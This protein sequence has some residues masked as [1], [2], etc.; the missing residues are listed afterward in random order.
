MGNPTVS[1]IIPTY[2]GARF[3]GEAMQS[4]FEQTYPDFELIV[5]N[6]ASPDNTCEAVKQFDD[7]RLIYLVHEENQGADVAR[8]TGLQASSGEIIAFLDQDDL[9]HPE[10]LQE[11]VIFLERDPDVGMTYNA[12]F[13]LNYSSKTIRELWRPPCSIT[14]ADLVLWFPISPS[15]S[16][17]RR[18][19]AFEMDLHSDNS[20]GSEISIL[21]HLFMSGCGFGLVDRALN[22]RRYH[23]RRKVKDLAR[24]CESELSNQIKVFSDARCPAEVLALRGV[25]HSNLYRYWSYLAFGQGETALGQKFVRE[26]VRLKPSLLEGRPCELVQFLLINCIDDESEN[27][28]ALLQGIFAQ[29][30]PEIAWLSEQS[31]WAVAQGYLLKGAR[32]VIWDRPEDGR[33]HFEHAANLC[34]QVDEPFLST[35][36]QKLLNYEA[37][38]G[39]EATQNVLCSLTPYLESLGDRAFVRDLKSSYSVNRAF[40]SYDAGD[41]ATVPM[42]ILHAIANN[43][44]YLANRGVVSILLRSTFGMWSKTV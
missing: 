10:K 3:L 37:E 30:P 34:A 17:L 12:R 6:D 4:V 39:V 13:E 24:A 2:N 33:R 11:H 8:H 19:W 40:R 38:F 35:L 5:V 18:K 28:E 14:L 15:D 44:K 20:R 29:M 21:S 7:P 25:A 16:V 41:Y 22:Y 32:A 9:F 36:T 23:S 42:T 43:P 26:A 31:S 27:H 1:V